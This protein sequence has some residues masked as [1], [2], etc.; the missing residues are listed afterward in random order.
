MPTLE[1]TLSEHVDGLVES[2]RREPFRHSMGTV[3]AIAE[4]INR[5]RGLELAV[6][7]L[8]VEV[9]RLQALV[10]PGRH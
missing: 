9:E 4:L 8:A 6:H 3:A 1:K 5:N 7:E 10:E 2:H